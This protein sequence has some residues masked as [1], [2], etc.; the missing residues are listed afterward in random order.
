MCIFDPNF[1][2]KMPETLYS[3]FTLLLIGMITVF[4]ILSLVVISGNL[5]IRLV[6]KYAPA[7]LPKKSSYTFVEDK[8]A[9]IPSQKVAVIVAAIEAVTEGKA[10]IVKIE[11]KE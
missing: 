11:R 8:A 9:A 3:A 7:P 4:T 6:N 10:R 5:L 2:I 1:H